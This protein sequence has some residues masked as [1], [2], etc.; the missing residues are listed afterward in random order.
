MSCEF[1]NTRREVRTAN[2]LYL[3]NGF[4][5][6]AICILSADCF[7]IVLDIAGALEKFTIAVSELLLLHDV[8]L[9]L[10]SAF[11]RD[12]FH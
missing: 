4:H 7:R 5:L 3:P 1:Y 11:V 10:R 12:N 8:E 2:S 9:S 6:P